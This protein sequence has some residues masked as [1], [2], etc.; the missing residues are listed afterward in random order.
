MNN[1]TVKD[2]LLQLIDS[3]Y[4]KNGTGI[5]QNELVNAIIQE[6]QQAG[7]LAVK[8][9]LQPYCSKLLTDLV[10][11]KKIIRVS[12]KKYIPFDTKEHPQVI[13]SLIV[14]SGAFIRYEF[15]K[16]S[17]S[18]IYLDVHRDQ[19]TNIGELFKDYLKE[20]CFDVY[21][22]NRYLVLMLNAHSDQADEEKREKEEKEALR[23]IH[24]EISDILEKAKSFDGAPVPKDLYGNY[25]KKETT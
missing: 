12:K 3:H 7:L 14:E 9:T 13:K 5:T 8:K 22:L 18:L 16:A 24:A 23:K 4:K 1:I 10:L 6:R 15:F 17:D 20:D 21:Q 11:M 19:I 2:T 25:K